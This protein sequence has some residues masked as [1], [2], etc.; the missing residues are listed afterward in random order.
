FRG[1]PFGGPIPLY[2]RVVPPNL[3]G[4]YFIGLVQP[5]GAVM[6]IA[7]IQSQWVADLLAGR[8]ALPPEPEMNREIARYRTATA[9]RYRRPAEQA[10][11]VDFLGY[12]REIRRERRGGARRHRTPPARPPS[13]PRPRR[14]PRPPA[15]PPPRPPT[16]P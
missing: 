11:Q 14:A 12:V 10:I 4:L 16:P 5:I 6:P 3:P 13:P 9:K 15:P 1:G 8:A 7:E 2:R